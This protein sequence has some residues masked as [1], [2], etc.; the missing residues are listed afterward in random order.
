MKS[1]FQKTVSLISSSFILLFLL[2]ALN[3]AGS[4]ILLWKEE[5][6]GSITHDTGY[7]YYAFVRDENVSRLGL[8][9]Y[10]KEDETLLSNP[11]LSVNEDITATIKDRGLGAHKIMENNDLYFSASDNRPENHE[12]SIISPVIIRNRYLLVLFCLAVLSAAMLMFQSYKSKNKKAVINPVRFGTILLFMLMLLP[13]DLMVFSSAS[14]AFGSYIIKPLLQR[15]LIFICLLFVLLL[16]NTLFA[17]K[18]RFL[19]V[20][21]AAVVLLNTVYY[22]VPE[23]N[24]F[25]QRA[26]SADYIEHYTASSI[27]TPGYPIFIE[28][29]YS[30]TGSG[31]L[32]EIRLERDNQPDERLTD[33][34]KTDSRGLIN[35]ARAQKIVLAAAFLILFAVYARYYPLS[36][37]T[38][39]AQIILCGGFLGVDNSYIMT[40]CLSQAVCLIIAALFILCMKEK[41]SVFF[42][43]L[44]IL[45]G[46]GMLIR[47]ANIFLVIPIGICFLMLLR[48]KIDLLISVIGVLAFI[49]IT[50]IPAVTI[51]SQYKVFVWM[52][53]SGYVDAARAVE[54][55]QPGD[56]DTFEDPELREFCADLMKKKAELGEADQNTYM[57]EAAIATAQEHGYDLISCSPILGK[58]SR[59][60]FRLHPREFVSA[61]AETLKTALTRTRLQLG[62]VPFAGLAVLFLILFAVNINTDS[63]TGFIL[64]LMHIAHLFIF[65]VNQPERRYIYSTEILC[66]IGWLLILVSLWNIK[67]KLLDKK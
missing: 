14:K 30:L 60:I 31:G 28:T 12:Y 10:L 56:E 20:L 37:F 41:N 67:N 42:L 2:A 11:P 44:C 45:A 1:T 50:A 21:A 47:P 39:A 8:P 29:V 46:F 18:S 22:F 35:I 16:L 4:L 62:P 53:T 9:F 5:P 34:T 15:N 13:W 65:I 38:F 27:R 40:E 66:L 26:D 24:Y 54:L 55:M 64:S 7:G 3:R 61:L 63:L 49:G 19:V 58:I 43:F 33:G 25:G 6:L 36:W 51:Y 23:W 59:H 52:P 32:D 57:W 17:G 48:E